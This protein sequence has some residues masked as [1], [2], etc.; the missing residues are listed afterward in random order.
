LQRTAACSLTIVDSEERL[1]QQ[2]C[3]HLHRPTSTLSSAQRRLLTQAAER[4]PELMGVRILL[5]DDDVRNVFAMTSALE[6]HGASVAYADN[7]KA[8][9]E[10]LDAAHDIA[11]V[12]VDIVLPDMDGYQV[13]REIRQRASGRF[14]PVIAVTAKAMPA[15]R[16]KCFQAGATHYIAKPLDARDLISALRVAAFH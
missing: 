13:M 9:L 6:R 1:L 12:L 15:D 2:A 4:A 3:L 11:A 10:L 8:G 5:I 14:L 7:G 16:D